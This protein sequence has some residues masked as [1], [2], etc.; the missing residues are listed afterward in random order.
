M[1]A[2]TAKHGSVKTWAFIVASLGMLGGTA[3]GPRTTPSL[4]ITLALQADTVSWE[5]M[6]G[7]YRFPNRVAHIHFFDQDGQFVA[8]QVWDGRTY[9]LHRTGPLTF[10]SR[11]EA[12]KIEFMEG[13]AG[14]IDKVKVLGRV[15]LEKVSYNPTRY[16]EPTAERVKPLLGLYQFQKDKNMEISLSI[17]DGK[18]ALKQHWDNKT[19][20]FDA[21]SPTE[22]F[23]EELTF[24]LTFNVE[25]GVVKKLTCF[26]S[27]VWFK[28][29]GK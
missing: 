25:N 6:T 11:D 26:E 4:A 8:Q 24:P 12:Y 19:I 22:F 13:E 18:L 15:I 1:T 9:P 14:T 27:D 7:Y 10:Q 29:E 17:Q 16:I 3:A 21:Y 20:L 2:K 23:N 28:K 5:T